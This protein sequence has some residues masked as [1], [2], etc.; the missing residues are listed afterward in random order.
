[1]VS[2]GYVAWLA[3]T[4]S[5]ILYSPRGVWSLVVWSVLPF[6][7]YQQYVDL[8]VTS[9]AEYSIRYKNKRREIFRFAKQFLAQSVVFL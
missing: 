6:C 9:R 3:A 2:L 8:P 4:L 7:L 1:M 5:K